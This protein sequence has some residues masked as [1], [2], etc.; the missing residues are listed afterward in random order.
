MSNSNDL[1][2]EEVRKNFKR[3]LDNFDNIEVYVAYRPKA[4][5][6]ERVSIPPE[7]LMELVRDQYGT[8]AKLMGVSSQ[9]ILEFEAYSADPHC[10]A[11]NRNG[12]PCEAMVA[13]S[14][15]PRT[16][17]QYD[18]AGGHYCSSHLKHGVKRTI[19]RHRIANAAE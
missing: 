1:D 13:Y 2:P 15:L 5:D 14:D 19:T 6:V 12:K 7:M 11:L 16:P 4:M 3:L 10:F 17:A 8:L 9:H 18:P